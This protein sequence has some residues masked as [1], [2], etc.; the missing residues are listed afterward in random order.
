MVLTKWLRPGN[1][2]GPFNWQATNTSPLTRNSYSYNS[3]PQMGPLYTSFNRPNIELRMN[4]GTGIDNE[5]TYSENI[6]SPNPANDF[7]VFKEIHFESEI[8]ITDM[9]G[10]VVLKS[11]LP[12]GNLQ[13]L[14]TSEL[15][16]GVYQVIVSSKEK[17]IRK[18]LIIS[19]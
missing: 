17:T 9:T 16:N 1:A 18:K 11:S 7:I 19:K 3:G 5:L 12:Q 4:Q 2:T 6:F 10:K 15:V 13:T 14:N 8:T